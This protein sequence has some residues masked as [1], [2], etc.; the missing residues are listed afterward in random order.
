MWLGGGVIVAR[1]CLGNYLIGCVSTSCG[2]CGP[3]IRAYRVNLAL[4]IVVSLHL[5]YFVLQN[6]QKFDFLA[7]GAKLLA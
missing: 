1:H 7:D 2:Q 6:F 4:A 5:C 3:K